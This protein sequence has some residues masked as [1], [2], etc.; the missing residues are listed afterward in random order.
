MSQYASYSGYLG[1]SGGGGSGVS[2]LNGETGAVNIVAGSG[3][4]VTPAGQNITIANTGSFPVGTANTFAGFDNT[5]AL[6]SV[7]GFNINTFGGMDESLTQSPNNGTFQTQN[8]FNVDFTPLQNSPNE[9]WN[10]QSIQASLDTGSSGFTQGTNGTAVQLLNLNTTH[11]G[12]GS[13]GGINNITMN[14][15]IGNGTDVITVKGMGMSFGF[16]QIHANV[17]LDGSLQGYTFQPNVDAA[18][19]GTSNFSVSAFE[20]FSNISIPVNGYQ[21]L[22]SGPNITA[23]TNN[24]GF[25]GFN[26]NPIIITFQGNSG[27]TGFGSA[28]NITTMSATGQYSGLQVTP[29]I[30][31]SHGSIN[32]IQIS[33]TVSGGDAS[34]TGIRINPNGAVVFSTAEGI[35]INLNNITSAEAQGVVGINSDS[36]I[37][38]NAVTQLKAAQGFQIGNR[39]E[40]LFHVPPGS[41]VTGTDSLGNDFAGDLSAEDSIAL[42]PIGLGWASVGFIADMAVAVG[43]TVDAVDVFVPA[44]ALPDPGYTT[45]GTVTDMAMVRTFAPLS[46]G[47]TVAIT[48]LYGFKI[49][50][51]L[52]GPFSAAAT[53]AWGLYIEDVSL[54]NFIEGRLGIGNPNPIARLHTNAGTT[55]GT[56]GADAIILGKPNT[57]AN[58]GAGALI[59][60]GSSGANT[61]SGTDSSVFG[62]SNAATGIASFATGLNTIAQGQASHS[63]GNGG[64]AIGANS[65]VE[66]VNTLATGSSSH[67]EG[68][69]SQATALSAHAEGTST[70]ASGAQSHAEGF[71]TIANGDHCHAE[72]QST[73]A[74]GDSSHAEGFGSICIGTYSHSEGLNCTANGDKSHSS[75]EGSVTNSDNQT[76]VGL[77]N[78]PSGTAGSPAPTDEIFTVGNGTNSGSTHSCFAV[79]RDGLTYINDGHLRSTQATP[80]SPAAQSGAGT[81]A[82]SSVSNATDI[83]GKL[84]LVLGSAA[85][86]TGAQ[87]VITFNAAYV[88]A[89]TVVLTPR[90]ATAG[91][92][93]GDVYVTSTTADFT[94]NFATAALLTSTY[95]WFYH[96]IETA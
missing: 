50:S 68:S 90:N 81:G 91:L 46:Q 70:E 21:V 43:K 83:A 78:T 33:P 88:T 34:F 80:P 20:D 54:K 29:N 9:G 53:N 61:A 27:F 32:G 15:D 66:G 74:T 76:A 45:G 25:S 58:V 47:G 48:N 87:V 2:S 40:S 73:R 67:A 14:S 69:G 49:D 55:S 8:S 77:F 3:I 63:E 94:V 22:S 41:P 95:D 18:A 5:G 38:L 64:H 57:T 24:H 13:V 17:N 93:I 59:A 6:E 85:F 86:A 31:T 19:T 96:V 37:Q 82:S 92:N 23:I 52:G 72:G 79:R 42:G 30:T 28:G 75:G 60:S 1:G 62:N 10:I 4:S 51:A 36:R 11:H 26:L 12:T 89:P 65:H 35:N 84:E 56:V 71:A 44:V 39:V 16:S 7:P